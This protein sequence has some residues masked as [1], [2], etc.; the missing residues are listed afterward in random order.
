MVPNVN[1]GQPVRFYASL[2]LQFLDVVTEHLYALA[3]TN[4]QFEIDYAVQN[5]TPAGGCGV[6]SGDT[7][8]FKLDPAA[9]QLS[10]AFSFNFGW[11]DLQ[12]GGI[13]LVQ[14]PLAVVLFVVA[15]I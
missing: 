11:Q 10:A 2:Y 7:V 13:V 15:V 8:Q 3:T 4:N 9:Y 1:N 12:F 6:W 5:G 14:A